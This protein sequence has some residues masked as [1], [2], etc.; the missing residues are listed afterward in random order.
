MNPRC[1][2]KCLRCEHRAMIRRVVAARAKGARCF[3]CGGPMEI[4]E[5]AKSDLTTG[6]DTREAIK[7]MRKAREAF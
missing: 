2:A 6:Q 7:A 4:S 1:W 5:N 3:Q